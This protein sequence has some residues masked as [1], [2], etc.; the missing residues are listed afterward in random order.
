MLGQ[1]GA[2][3][4]AGGVL[5]GQQAAVAHG[6]GD[7]DEGPPVVGRIERLQPLAVLEGQH[8][9]PLDLQEEQ[10]LRPHPGQR[11]AGRG[12][13]DGGAVGVGLQPPVAGIDGRAGTAGQRRIEQAG[14]DHLQVGRLA[15]D[16]GAELGVR[17]AAGGI[18]RCEIGGEHAFAGRALGDEIGLERTAAP[19][20]RPAG[21]W[22]GALR[23]A[24]AM[25]ASRAAP[26]VCWKAA[27][28]AAWSSPV[29]PRRAESGRVRGSGG[30]GLSREGRGRAVRGR[31]PR[32]KGAEGR[33]RR[34]TGSARR[35]RLR[36]HAPATDPRPLRRRR[37]RASSWGRGSSGG[38]RRSTVRRCGGRRRLRP[39]G[40]WCGCG[41]PPGSA[42]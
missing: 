39:R 5:A 18:L 26:Q 15:A 30:R 7:A 6:V 20:R 25:A 22:R 8:A 34:P 24:S 32:R 16:R 10:V 4:L 37:G 33:R 42:R 27:S 11:P 35:A 9:G 13:L 40:P 1:P 2:D 31:R 19:G 23:Q 36:R 17:R 38:A 14:V 21:R 12:R 41:I 29:Q 3:R 28:A